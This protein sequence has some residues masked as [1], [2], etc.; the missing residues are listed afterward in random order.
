MK[1]H[2]I[3]INRKYFEPIRKGE[4]KLLIFNKKVIHNEE[5]GDCIVAKIGSYDIK[6][7]IKRTYM[8]SF[9]EVTETEAKDAGFLNKDFLKDNLIQELDLNTVFSFEAGRTINNELLFFIELDFSEE[10]I[11]PNN[12][13]LYRREYDKNYYTINRP[14][15]DIFD[16]KI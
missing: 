5:P 2:D 8:K 9:E 4:I 15:R 14:W 16:E 11:L 3:N 12:V 13:D 1:M 6:A 7:K 10:K